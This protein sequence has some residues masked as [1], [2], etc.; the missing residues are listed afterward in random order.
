MED[1]IITEDSDSICYGSAKIVS[2]INFQEG[3]CCFF[4]KNK[5]MND[6]KIKNEYV[7]TFL[8]F[9]IE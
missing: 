1:F 3:I 7:K 8:N 6:D 5:L 4:D 9:N 2:K